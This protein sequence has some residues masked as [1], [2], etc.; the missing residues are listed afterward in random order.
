MK[1]MCS[2]VDK[3]GKEG[4]PGEGVHKS[5]PNLLRVATTIAKDSAPY[6]TANALLSLIER[7]PKDFGDRNK[8]VSL[9]L[10]DV[11]ILADKS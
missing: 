7:S 9:L 8:D 4:L 2:Q 11:L 6:K 1:K 10:S 3:R 5:K